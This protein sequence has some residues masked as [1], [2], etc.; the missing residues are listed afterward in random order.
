MSKKIPL[1]NGMYAIVDDEDYKRCMKYSWYVGVVRKINLHIYSRINNKHTPLQYFILQK[2]RN[3]EE[4]II[5][6]DQNRLNFRKENLLIG[7]KLHSSY[8]RKPHR[9]SSSKYKGV[10]WNKK[11][12]H[13]VAQIK[14]DKKPIYLGSFASE[15]EAAIA[16][17]QAA[18]KHFGELAFQ[19]EIGK[20]NWATEIKEK[21]KKLSGKMT[22]RYRG[23]YFHSRE[24]KYRSKVT[25]NK[26]VHHL[27]DFSGEFEAAKAYDRKAYELYGDKAILNFPELVEGYKK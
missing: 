4:T 25:K 7:T 22:S 21:N 14:T 12:K 27:G 3:S 8:S 18:I 6:K 20:E 16:Y 17:N 5:F 13:W 2:N 1:Q 26:T 15:E 23:V 24:N 9:N 11:R 10:S 19:N